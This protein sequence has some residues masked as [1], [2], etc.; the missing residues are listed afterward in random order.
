MRLIAFLLVLFSVTQAYATSYV[1]MSRDQAIKAGLGAHVA[2]QDALE[3]EHGAQTCFVHKDEQGETV[4]I[5]KG[6]SKGG[7]CTYIEHSESKG[8]AVTTVRF[9]NG[10]TF[11]TYSCFIKQ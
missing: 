10:M 1:H 8:G 5:I 4:A 6:S 9:P 2:R 11:T 7:Y 3:K